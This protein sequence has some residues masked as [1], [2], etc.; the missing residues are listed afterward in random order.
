VL[1]TPLTAPECGARHERA[2][3]SVAVDDAGARPDR[4]LLAH[5]IA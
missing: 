3:V 4:A 1:G 2:D 5:G